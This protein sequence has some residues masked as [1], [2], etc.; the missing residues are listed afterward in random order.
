MCLDVGHGL[1]K[2]N[3]DEM[4]TL[5][6]EHVHAQDTDGSSDQYLPVGRGKADFAGVFEQLK[7]KGYTGKVINECLTLED[8]VESVGKLK[9]F[10]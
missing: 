7:K 4:M 10:L 8:C 3:L 1:V 2:G 5:P 9:T 6:I